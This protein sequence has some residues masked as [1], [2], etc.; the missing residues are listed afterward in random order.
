MVGALDGAPAAPSPSPDKNAAAQVP[1][2]SIEPEP[3]SGG[4]QDDPAPDAAATP[5]TPPTTPVDPE[6]EIAAEI[7]AAQARLA[8]LGDPNAVA[9]AASDLLAK[10]NKDL[11]D[12]SRELE[13]A[14]YRARDHMRTT[15][16]KVQMDLEEKRLLL[17][18][19]GHLEAEAESI[20]TAKAAAAE[21]A[22]KAE[23]NA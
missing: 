23:G 5:P 21:A 1:Q 15:R 17:I 10:A 14:V 9:K 19:I 12:K 6:K 20:K 11:L 2:T 7:A 22:A 13:L 4:S 18:R 16:E 3:A 8:E